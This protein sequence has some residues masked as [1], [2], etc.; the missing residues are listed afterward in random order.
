[1]R[2]FWDAARQVVAKNRNQEALTM[3]TL[4][5]SLFVFS[6]FSMCV[7]DRRSEECVCKLILGVLFVHLLSRNPSEVNINVSIQL[8]Q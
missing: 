2:F 5:S 4:I 8:T 1:M 7:S 3:G 6:S